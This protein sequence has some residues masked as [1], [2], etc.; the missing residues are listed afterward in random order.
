M[1]LIF[2]HAGTERTLAK[3]PTVQLALK[4][5]E[6]T[7]AE[8]TARP[9][10]LRA[11]IQ[12]KEK[13]F[14]LPS[15]A[16]DAIRAA[17]DILNGRIE[18]PERFSAWL[19]TEEAKRG[20]TIGALAKDWLAAG[21][22][23]TKLKN[24]TPSAAARLRATLDRALPYWTGVVVAGISAT[25][26][27]NY[28]VHRK[29]NSK[30]GPGERSADLQLAALSCLCQWAVACGRIEANPFEVRQTYATVQK[31]CHESAPANDEQFHT[32]LRWLFTHEA[33]QKEI[34][35][36]HPAAE[37]DDR[38]R[39]IGGWLAF[40][41]LTGLRPG[42]PAPLLNVP[43]LVETPTETRT[44]PLGTVFP[45]PDGT[46]R[47]K[48]QRSKSGQNPFIIVRPA[49]ADFLQT[50]KNW[51]A[52]KLKPETLNPKLFPLDG[53]QGALNKALAAACA[54]CKL[55]QFKPHG[56]GRAYYVKVR[57]SQG[58]D[59]STIAGELG[60]TTNG[61]LIRSV[62]GVPDDM[63][64][65]DLHDWM[66]KEGAAAWDNLLAAEPIKNI[67]AL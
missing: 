63:A 22:P 66:P 44:L 32:V 3:H 42:E 27:D 4:R 20:V 59:D 51:M 47:M 29:A 14:K 36:R 50:W 62:Y 11:S 67:I 34:G 61:D 8:A 58:A 10:Y 46:Q 7:E 52:P 55:P 15:I 18:Q 65:G 5:G 43:A 64:G 35:N 37:V 48:I 56:F 53:D 16:K 9:W 21:L 60:Q 26:L 1:K 38:Q 30:R 19:A 39:I 33:D 45:A 54:A 28:V 31:H 49:L 24:R 25:S 41:A 2:T 40:C 57:R 12:G 17:K 6:I 23:H 13:Q